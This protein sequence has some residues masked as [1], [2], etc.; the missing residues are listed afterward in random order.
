MFVLKLYFINF[1][2]WTD[3]LPKSNY[4]DLIHLTKQAFELEINEHE[5]W[6]LKL[7]EITKL[8]PFLFIYV[9]MT[10]FRKEISF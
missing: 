3:I 7:I 6:I 4:R 10:L 1:H 8:S 2:S 9:Q 5:I